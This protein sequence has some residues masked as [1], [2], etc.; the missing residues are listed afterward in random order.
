[1]SKRS[2]YFVCQ[3]D[4]SVLLMDDDSRAKDA[5]GPSYRYRYVAT[6][7]KNHIGFKLSDYTQCLQESQSQT[8]RNNNIGQ[9]IIPAQFSSTDR[10]KLNPQQSHHPPPR[11]TFG[12]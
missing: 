11:S 4:S 6:G 12:A 5:R 1:M 2:N 9:R 7:R 10:F 3:T 8:N